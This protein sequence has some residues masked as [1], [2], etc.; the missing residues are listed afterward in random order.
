MEPRPNAYT[1]AVV[2]INVL[3]VHTHASISKSRNQMSSNFQFQLN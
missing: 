3:Q 2:Y 1:I